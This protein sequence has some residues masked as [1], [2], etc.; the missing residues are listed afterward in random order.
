MI[1]RHRRA[2]TPTSGSTWPS[3][4]IGAVP[5]TTTRSPTRIAAAV[6]HDG[7]ERGAGA[8]RARRAVHGRLASAG[9]RSDRCGAH[10]AWSGAD[11]SLPVP[12]MRRVAIGAREPSA[13]RGG[14]VT[15]GPRSAT[16][17]RAG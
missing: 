10:A 12:T 3:G 6:A 8:A 11:P 1:S 14:A 2:W 16:V 5:P 17:P 4:Q 7:L 15:Q 13:R 9:V